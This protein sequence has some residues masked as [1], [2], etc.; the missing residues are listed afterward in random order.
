MSHFSSA[1]RAAARCT[2]SRDTAPAGS[3]RTQE[4]R[5]SPT[6]GDTRQ[7][8]GDDGGAPRLLPTFFCAGYRS[9][10]LGSLTAARTETRVARTRAK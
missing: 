6:R 10:A 8:G 1:T 3:T 2:K 7:T 5:P 9:P 4:K